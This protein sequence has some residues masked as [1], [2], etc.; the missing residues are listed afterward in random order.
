MRRITYAGTELYTGDRIAESL[1]DY[2]R[3]LAREGSS[4]TV[5]VPGRTTTGA[6]GGIEVLIGPA[7]QL[8]SEPVDSIEPEIEDAALVE[9]LERLTAGLDRFKPAPEPHPGELGF[10]DPF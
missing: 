6:V 7:S 4:D 3:A 1:L 8:V 2:A 9:K 5:F 10:L